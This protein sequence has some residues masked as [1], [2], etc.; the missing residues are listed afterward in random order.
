LRALGAGVA[1]G[2][3]A[4]AGIFIVGS[5]APGL[6]HSL[7]T[8]RALPAVIV[9]VAAGVAA[10]VLVYSRRFE[11]ARY[12]AALAVSSFVA[13]WALSRWPKILPGLTVHQAAAGHDTLVWVIVAVLVGGAIVFPSLG[14]LFRLTLAGRFRSAES[15]AGGVAAAGLRSIRTGLLARLAVAC[16]I[17]GFGLLNVADAEWAHGVGVV[18]LF[19]FV[20]LAFRVIVSSVLTGE[21]GAAR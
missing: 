2:A 6:R 18:C 21:E 20:A 3:V 12:G 9:S 15:D 5:D 19:G 7:L 10:L 4:I 1:A 14:L 13:G 11:P 16:L 8:G 17:A